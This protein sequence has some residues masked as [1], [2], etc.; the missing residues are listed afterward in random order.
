MPID[1]VAGT[2][3]MRAGMLLP[4]GVSVTSD[5][6]SRNWEV[7]TNPDT[8]GM[9]R[10]LR[11]A[12][13]SLFFAAAALRAVTFGRRE[14]KNARQAVDRILSRVQAQNFNCV[15]ITELSTK[16]FLGIPYMS[17]CAHA[18]QIQQGYTLQGDSGRR[19]A[20]RLADWARN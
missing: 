12:G 16:H 14:G 2:V 11:E 19:E 15:E 13:W 1:I 8:F 7:I 18:R 4:R 17:V 5:P 9:D 20:Q 6:Y 10:S 3:L